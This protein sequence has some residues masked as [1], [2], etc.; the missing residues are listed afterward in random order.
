V[1]GAA[2]GQGRTKHRD[3]WECLE[4]DQGLSQ[5]ALIT[6]ALQDFRQDEIT[7]DNLPLPEQVVQGIGVGVTC[8]L[9]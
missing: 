2:Y 6:E 4:Q 5:V 1:F 9:K 8:P 7:Y 3:D